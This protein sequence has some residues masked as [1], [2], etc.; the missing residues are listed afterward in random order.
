[1]H[2]CSGYSERRKPSM[3]SWVQYVAQG[4]CIA[5]TAALHQ[6]EALAPHAKEKP[7]PQRKCKC[8]S[9]HYHR[10]DARMSTGIELSDAAIR[11]SVPRLHL[12]VLLT[13]RR[14]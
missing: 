8:H 13:E 7:L 14:A 1:M 3:K 12:P 6:L 10:H 11:L 2:Q 4:A 9:L 5:S